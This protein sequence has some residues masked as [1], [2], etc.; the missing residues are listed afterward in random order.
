M[1]NQNKAKSQEEPLRTQSQIDTHFLKLDDTRVSKSKLTGLPRL[2]LPPSHPFIF[3][4]KENNTFCGIWVNETEVS[5]SERLGHNVER[6]ALLKLIKQRI[7]EFVYPFWLEIEYDVSSF[8]FVHNLMTKGTLWLT[9]L[10]C[11]QLKT[12][13]STSLFLQRFNFLEYICWMDFTFQIVTIL[14]ILT[15]VTCFR[16]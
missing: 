6:E 5:G 1:A 7:K 3:T 15:S 14:N 4:L 13:K 16:R 11:V 9:S 8:P 12:R 2:P 10:D